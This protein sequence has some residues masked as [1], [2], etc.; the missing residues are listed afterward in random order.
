MAKKNSKN[1]KKYKNIILYGF[2]CS[3]K[4]NLAEKISRKL[5]FKFQDT[6][7]L[8]EKKYGKIKKFVEKYGFKKFRKIEKEIFKK[9]IKKRNSIIAAGGGIFPQKLSTSLEIFLNPPFKILEKRFIKNKEKRPLLLE[10]PK[11]KK[12]IIKLYK[13]RLKKYRKAD[14]EIKKTNLK[15]IINLIK[16]YYE[17]NQP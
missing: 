14:F 16:F 11:N 12:E 10:Y 15:E 8:F 7:L 2:M 13:E 3:G 5:N 1:S 9:T 4:T 17:N 6:D